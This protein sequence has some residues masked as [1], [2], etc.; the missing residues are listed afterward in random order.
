MV[1][2]HPGPC[3]P[4]ISPFSSASLIFT[5]IRH[6]TSYSTLSNFL[7][8]GMK[9]PSM[10]PAGVGTCMRTSTQHRTGHWHLPT[11]YWFS[12]S[13][14]ALGTVETILLHLVKPTALG[15]FNQP[16][17]RARRAEP[18][19]QWGA[20]PLEQLLHKVS[21]PGQGFGGTLPQTGICWGAHTGCRQPHPPCTQAGPEQLPG[22]DGKKGP[23]LPIHR[24]RA[25]HRTG[26][27]WK[28]PAGAVNH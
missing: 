12:V 11:A 19:W 18:L 6:R 21:Q 23:L 26:A 25:Q 28:P 9:A 15:G 13:L 2:K 4:L 1:I 8:R 16:G 24:A 20:G 3:A 22:K 5:G 7:V 14:Q 27:A 10:L 17:L